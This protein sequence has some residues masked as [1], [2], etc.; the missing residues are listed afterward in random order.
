MVRVRVSPTKLIDLINYFNF[1]SDF[2]NYFF[3]AI[4][5]FRKINNMIEFDDEIF[6]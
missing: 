2:N 4:S 3:I 5:L 1:V 6:T